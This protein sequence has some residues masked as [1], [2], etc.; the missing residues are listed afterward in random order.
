MGDDGPALWRRVELPSR[1]SLIAPF[2]AVALL[3]T[4]AVVI[5]PGRDDWPHLVLLALTSTLC[6]TLFVAS[7]RAR[8]D[9]RLQL[10]APVSFLAV[11][12]V[13]RD[14]AGGGSS[15]VSLLLLPTLWLALT[16]TLRQ[17][18]TAGVLTVFTIV[19]PILLIGGE[20]YPPTEWRR[21]VSITAIVAL[22]TPIVHRVVHL[23]GQ[24]T[25]RARLAAEHLDGLMR[26]TVGTS[27]VSFDLDGVIRSFNV[28]AEELLGLAAAEVVDRVPMTSLLDADEL[29]ALAREFGV[30]TGLEALAAL[31]ARAEPDRP[32]TYRTVGGEEVVVRLVLTQLRAA[33]GAVTGHLAVGHDTTEMAAAQRALERANDQFRRLFTDAPHGVVLLD[34]QGRVVLVNRSMRGILG[35]TT[36]RMLGQPL[37][38]FALPGDQ[39]VSLHLGEVID[40]AGRSVATDCV[41]RNVRG[42]EVHVALTSRL[43]LQADGEQDV[44]FV[45]VVDVSER[46]RYQEQLSHLVDHDVLTGL[47]NR[48]RFDSELNRRLAGHRLHGTPGALLWI[49]LDHFKQVNDTLGHNAGDQML[50]D[51]ASIL[52]RSVR[53]S[54]LVARLGGDEFALLLA[55]VDQPGAVAVAE[56]VVEAVAEYAATR[57]GVERRLTCSIGVVTFRSA[58]DQTE[59]DIVALA[60]MTMYDA[61]ES[62]RNRYAVL[63]EGGQQQP[64]TGVRLEWQRRIEEA[65]EG[66]RF[67][68]FLQPILD[69][70]T[71]R[72][73]SAEVLLRMR[74]EEGELFAPGRFLETA[75][76]VGLM[77][78]VD[79]WVIDHAIEMLARLRLVAPGFQLEVNLSGQ[80][81]GDAAIEETITRALAR[82]RVDPAALILEVTETV[83]IA[84]VGLA[85]E[86]AERMSDIGCRFALDD[87]G[88]GF[89]SFYYLK[90]LIFDY[91]KID[92]EFVATL[93]GSE[94][95]RSIVRSIVAIAHDLGK[96]TVAEFVADAEVLE[97][98]RAKGV[99]LAQGYH[100]GRP[101]PYEEF[102]DNLRLE[103]GG[104][105]A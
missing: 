90:H 13:S 82:H 105:D 17:L 42:M 55:D 3:G 34:R 47:A 9:A 69:L 57:Q 87:F 80:S 66:D 81:M 12:A 75:E 63:P 72:V 99:D 11:M 56:K 10:F 83:A 52:T 76:R 43:M 53:R 6:V 78:A 24:E 64:R 18:V 5:P 31:A 62:G 70:A 54:D 96:Q 41:L 21:V 38:M 37:A 104:L 60:D 98:V 102:V 85:R 86:F 36:E 1:G 93:A 88:A 67:V 46:R 95:D 15:G 29:D 48:R 59:S 91:V 32:F 28:G 16:G 73:V 45:N 103:M 2:A 97:I 92:G 89:G 39:T 27:M 23:L 4:A 49:D 20:H 84:D 7:F 30:A 94:V 100:I 14:I 8:D 79:R 33:D 58:A 68:I 35:S 40:A 101:V 50:V 51:I 44:I 71:D 22:L 61:K 25:E 26:G 19:A 74:G 65:L 77:P